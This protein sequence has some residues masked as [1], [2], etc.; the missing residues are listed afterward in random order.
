MAVGAIIGAVAGFFVGW[1]IAALRS[2][3]TYLGGGYGQFEGMGCFATLGLCVVLAAIGA[4]IG[5]FLLR[6]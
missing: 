4:G 6:G 1:L 2:R 3:F 5:A